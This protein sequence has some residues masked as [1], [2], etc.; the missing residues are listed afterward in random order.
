MNNVR[1]NVINELQK[2]FLRKKTIV[3]LILTAVVSF[4]PAL[5]IS[6]IQAKL[7]FVSLNSVSFPLINLS[8]FTNVLL[9]LFI[10]LAAAELFAGEV[11][12]RTMKLVLTRP[13]SRFKV[14][15]SKTLALAIYAVIILLVVFIISTAS[16]IIFRLNSQNITGVMFSYIIDI[17]PAFVLI[18]FSVL[19]VQFFRSSSAALIS[20]ILAYIGIRVISLLVKGFSNVAFTSYLNWYSMWSLQ[21]N[22]IFRAINTLLMMAAY[23]LIFFT[24]G[25]YVFDKKEF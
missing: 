21:G 23:G 15:L 17:I 24:L 7:M 3:F 19:I 12:N 22:T 6:A 10:F 20:S 25:Y 9:P 18:I 5:F 4:L 1:A 11:G 16:A 14:F 8:I 2:L 13:I